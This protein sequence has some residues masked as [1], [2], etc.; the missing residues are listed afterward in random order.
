ML[1]S[2]ILNH[3][4]SRNKHKWCFY[5]LLLTHIHNYSGCCNRNWV[6]YF[7]G[8][9]LTYNHNS[10]EERDENRP[11]CFSTL[12]DI[13]INS[14]TPPSIDEGTKIPEGTTITVPEGSYDSYKDAEGW[15]DKNIQAPATKIDYTVESNDIQ[16]DADGHNIVVKGASDNTRMS[17]VTTE[18]RLIYQGSVRNVEIHTAGLYIVR[19]N[20]TVKKILVK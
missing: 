19:I 20:N 10:T 9:L 16:V 17:I 3:T 4:K 15:K 12:K 18:G 7:L 13:T 6:L 2:H 11:H 1:L 14:T 5:K 8:V